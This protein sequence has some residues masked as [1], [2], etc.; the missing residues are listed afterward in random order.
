MT[1]QPRQCG[2]CTICVL[3]SQVHLPHRCSL[4]GVIGQVLRICNGVNL[5]GPCFLLRCDSNL[6][7]LLITSH[8]AARFPYRDSLSRSWNSFLLFLL[9]MVILMWNDTGIR[10]IWAVYF[11]SDFIQPS[12]VMGL[13]LLFYVYALY[14]FCLSFSS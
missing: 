3:Y 12:V 14:K 10:L 4:V 2:G 7:V 6:S 11:E 1:V 13:L 8:F 9:A 5:P